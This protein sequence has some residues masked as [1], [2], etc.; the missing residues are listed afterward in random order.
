LWYSQTSFLI[1]D[2]NCQ[3]D[4]L[5]HYKKIIEEPKKIKILKDYDNVIVDFKPNHKDLLIEENIN[6]FCN[7]I[8]IIDENERFCDLLIKKYG[9]LIISEKT[10][11]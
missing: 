8:F 1:D 11:T 10:L 4:N 3:N 6:K 9:I 5:E 2:S 7:D